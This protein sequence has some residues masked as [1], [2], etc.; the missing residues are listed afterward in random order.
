M[1]ELLEYLLMF[2]A[3]IFF[4]N[5]MLALMFNGIFGARV[6][7]SVRNNEGNNFFNRD[8]YQQIMTIIVNFVMLTTILWLCIRFDIIKL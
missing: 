1:N 5:F 7:E 6:K 4:L 3:F 2:I 8:K